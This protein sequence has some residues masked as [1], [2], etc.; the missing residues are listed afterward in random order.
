[1]QHI[2][3]VDLGGDADLEC[4]LHCGQ[5]GL[6]AMLQNENQALDHLPVAS[7]LPEQMLLQLL[8]SFGQFCEGSAVAQST[9][10]A[11]DNRQIRFD[12]GRHATVR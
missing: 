11:L 2:E 6:L 1:M 4:H 5:H 3:D 12:R 9:G 10:L 8:E 7:G